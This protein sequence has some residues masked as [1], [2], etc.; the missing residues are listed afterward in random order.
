MPLNKRI[1]ITL[2]I[3]PGVEDSEDNADAQL[4]RQMTGREVVVAVI[5]GSGYG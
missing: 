3:Q 4:T 2:G 1:Q 5:P